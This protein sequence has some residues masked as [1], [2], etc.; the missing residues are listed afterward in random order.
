MAGAQQYKDVEILF[1]LKAI[2][3]G[4]SLRW[5]IAMFE[6]RFGRGL[7]E[8]QVRYIKNKYG[9]DPRFGT[10][11]A[12]TQNFGISSSS[13]WPESDGVLDIDFAQFE[14]QDAHVPQPNLRVSSFPR[15]APS[16]PHSHS[17]SVGG[18]GAAAAASSPPP[19]PPKNCPGP[20]R[21]SDTD[22]KGAAV[23]GQKRT[24]DGE[25]D[26]VDD[27]T[28]SLDTDMHIDGFHHYP[29]L[30]VSEE[31]PAHGVTAAWEEELARLGEEEGL[32]FLDGPTN[33][34]PYLLAW[35]DGE[36]EDGMDC[37]SD[38]KASV[39]QEQQQQQQQQQ[40][41]GN[42]GLFLSQDAQILWM[43]QHS[44]PL[45]S[46]FPA[47]ND[48]LP[49][50]G[51]DILID[52]YEHRDHNHH[53]AHIHRMRV[54]DADAANVA[55]T[56]CQQ[57]AATVH[58]GNDNQQALLQ[59]TAQDNTFQRPGP[60]SRE[61]SNSTHHV[62]QTSD[63][64][65]AKPG[66]GLDHH[67]G[68]LGLQAQAKAQAPTPA[69]AEEHKNEPLGPLPNEPFFPFLQYNA[70]FV[71]DAWQTDLATCANDNS[72]MSTNAISNEESTPWSCPE[73]WPSP[74]AASLAPMEAQKAVGS[75]DGASYQ[76]NY[77][78][79]G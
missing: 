4:L 68:R 56:I 24:H 40:H 31:F 25:D 60:S 59:L 51:S 44:L 11:M 75:G 65:I 50:S 70:P 26:D 29:G 23:A 77:L 62:I 52:S 2:L 54:P 30:P 7:T 8:N 1:V 35:E 36:E 37:L 27:L 20:L 76:A 33:V 45:G 43:D 34:E 64:S 19:R 12:N 72:V 53:A 42:R 55:D 69:R 28:G 78:D 41:E 13:E 3:R 39:Q 73:G 32:S 18:A 63:N 6:S 9:R 57:L 22:L 14:R 16:T 67:D 79:G 61:N 48:A 46:Q 38:A 66:H 21:R 74:F 10:P 58:A 15:T 5:I 71:H 17:L 49:A 47:W